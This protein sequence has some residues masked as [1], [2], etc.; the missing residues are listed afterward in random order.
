MKN[1]IVIDDLIIVSSF[2][3]SHTRVRQANK[4][5]IAVS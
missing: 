5:A 2:L 3:M 1:E 4:L